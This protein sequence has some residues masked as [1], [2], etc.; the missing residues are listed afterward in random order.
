MP[1]PDRSFAVPRRDPMRIIRVAICL[2]VTLL[3]AALAAAQAPDT[4]TIAGTVTSTNGLLLP[5]AEITIWNETIAVERRVST[6]ERGAYQVGD[7]PVQGVYTVRAELSGFATMLEKSITLV[8]GERQLID[9]AMHPATSETLVVTGRTPTIEHEHS[10]VQQLVGETLV[11]AI[12]LISRDFISLTSLTAGFTGNPNFPSPQGQIYWA[13]N[14][15]VDGASHFSK[16][17]GAARTFYSGYGL[18]TIREVQVLTSQFSAEYGE[19]LATVT[20]AST[21]SGTNEVHGSGLFFL[22]N[23][24]LND[25]P[26]F[27]TETPPSGQQRFGFTIGGP[28]IQDRSHYF[29]SYEGRRARLHNVVTSPAAAGQLVPSDEDE[30]ILFFKVDHKS[31]TND[32]LTVRYNGQ[33]FRWS[34][35][36]GG[37]WLPGSGTQFKNDVHTVLVSHT[38]LL[39][40]ATLNQFRAQFAHFVDERLDLNPTLYIERIGYSIEGGLIGPY[41]FGASPEKTFEIADTLSHKRGMHSF[42]FGFGLKDVRSHNQSLARGFGALYYAGGPGVATSPFAFARGVGTESQATTDPH[43]LSGYGFVQDDWRVSSRL[44]LNLGVRYDVESISNV[45]GYTASA[46]RNN[47]QPRLGVAWEPMDDNL[48]VRG[49]LGLYTQQH[50]LYAIGRV[51]LEGPDGTQ[52]YN[53]IPGQVGFNE[54]TPPPRDIVVLDPAFHSPYSLQATAGVERRILGIQFGADYI[55]LRGRELMSLIDTNPPASISESTIRSVAAAD[56]TRPIRPVSGGFREII[57]LGNEGQSWYHGLQVKVSQSSGQVQTMASY[58][59][60][61][62]E[63]QANFQLPEDSRNLDA[64]RGRSDSDIR[65]NFVVGFTWQLP[66]GP[67]ALNGWTLSGTAQV[68]SNRPYTQTWGNDQ[69][70]TTQNDA[71][72]GGRNTLTTGTYRNIDLSLVRQFHVGSKTIEGRLEAFN[73]FSMVNYNEYIGS[74]SAGYYDSQNVFRSL[75]SQPVTAFPQRRLQLAAVVRF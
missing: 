25:R 34:D 75:Y 74:L 66:G 48:V 51:D 1:R 6:D 53:A 4:A 20:L 73:V 29:G 37:L 44:S 35:E 16:W 8:R 43:S 67:A 11:H 54:A 31:N 46:D 50:L 52:I 26:I 5:G 60:S 14:V 42:K 13:N 21:K 2:T 69:N 12:P 70:G 68:R 28:I 33:R 55:Y 18:E 15:L 40:N 24:A 3:T 57:A 47:I 27:T 71:R 23:G 36:P 61:T 65:H 62:A 59:L 41:P 30:H 72:P 9:I 49:G 38:R 10:A 56:L 7:L 22:Q 32:L 19:S 64:E 63:D 39:S 45:D 58:T 17:R